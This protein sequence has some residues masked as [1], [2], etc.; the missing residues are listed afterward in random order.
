MLH[1]KNLILIFLLL[2][3]NSCSN[4]ELK[5]SSI[6]EKDLDLQV[7][8]AYEEGLKS[9][10]NGDVLFAAKKFNEVEV[11]FPQ[12]KWAPKSSLMA[13]YSY[14]SQ[15]YYEDAIIELQRYL[16]T[17]PFHVNKDYAYYILALSYYEQI[18]DEKKDLSSIYNAKK[19]F[20]YLI[21]NFPETEYTSDAKFKNELINDI[22]ASKEIY[23]GRYYLEK[24]KWIP[25]IN[26]FRAV[27]DL[28]D[29]TI[30]TEEALYRLVEIYYM[31]GL[32]DESFKYA[33][34]LGYNYKSS[35]WYERSYSFFDKK[36]KINNKV[37]EKKS[38]IKKFKSF[39][40]N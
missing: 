13:A 1:Y 25:A 30:Y 16:K 2:F 6:S 28:Y 38:I 17:Y 33:K 10:K 40:I 31:L 36:Y 9:L 20:D 4:I 8:E 29:T 39:L 34:L 5:K 26:R 37:K 12:S 11:L 3:L 27:I 14:Y 32:K 15:D 18:A 21:N 24:K 22:L 7:L 23:L 19:Y 35:K